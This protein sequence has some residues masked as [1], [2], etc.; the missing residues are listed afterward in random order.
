MDGNSL[1]DL[2]RLYVTKLDRIDKCV[3]DN[4]DYIIEVILIISVNLYIIIK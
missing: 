1:S 2:S 4:C 3:Y